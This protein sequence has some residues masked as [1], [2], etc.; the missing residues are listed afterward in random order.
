MKMSFKSRVSIVIIALSLIVLFSTNWICSTFQIDSFEILLFTI[1]MPTTGTSLD[2]IFSGILYCLIIPLIITVVVVALCMVFKKSK[3]IT[4]NKIY[5]FLTSKS[6]FISVMLLVCSVINLYYSLGIDEYIK[7]QMDKT[8]I[9]EEYY[10]DPR[11]VN[12][13]FPNKK[14]NLIFIY[15]ESMETTFYSKEQGGYFDRNI[16]PELYDLAI[17]STCFANSNKQGFYVAPTTGSTIS[18]NIGSMLGIPL[19]SM[20]AG[21]RSFDEEYFLPGA[22]GLGDILNA[23]GYTNVFLCGEDATFASTDNFFKKHGNYKIHDYK[24]ASENEWIPD[25]YYVFWGYEDQKLF[26]FAKNE[27]L[28]LASTNK[29]F[30]LVIS[31]IDTHHPDGYLC[32]NC[33]DYYGNQL[34]NSYRCSS[35]QVTNFVNW[36]KEQPFYENTTIVIMGDHISHSSMLYDIIDEDYQR[37]CYFTIINS[38]KESD[39]KSSRLFCTFDIFPT[40]LA[41]LGVEFNSDRLALGTNLFSN[42]QTLLEQLGEDFFNELYKTSDYYNNKIV[43]NR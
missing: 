15:L 3:H 17:N 2:L 23:N 29:P 31:T 21:N 20:F 14:R 16:I 7:H 22:Y 27:A 42:S 6:I 12:Y 28:S 32:D 36:V 37:K 25:D 43:F 26:Q 13:V 41:S 35:K 40:T 5:F 8:T 30:S 18:A 1:L 9:Y 39:N 10:V 4:L 24:Y 38:A 33:I 34:F 11:N 19:G